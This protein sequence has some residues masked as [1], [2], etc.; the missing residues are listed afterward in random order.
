M[1]TIYHNPLWSKSRKSVE[2]LNEK[3]IEFEI[4]EYLKTGIKKKTL[5]DI[6]KKLNLRPKDFIRKNDEIFKD[7]KLEK[8]IENDEKIFDA[9][10]KNPKLIERPIVL[11]KNKGIIARP[12]ELLHDF[13]L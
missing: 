11:Q 3:K 8:V 9:I 12:P 5:I 4:I 1:T 2:I 6:S 7:E 13:L 10:I